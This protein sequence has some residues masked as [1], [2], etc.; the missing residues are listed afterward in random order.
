VIE[1]P[2][3]KAHTPKAPAR[4]DPIRAGLLCRCPRCGKGKLFSGFLEVARACDACGADFTRL[5]TG[6]GATVF[7]IQ[8]TG[9][10][11][12]FGL[13]FTQ[14]ALNPPLWVLAAVWL[15]LTALIGLGLMRPLK[16]AMIGLQIRNRAGEVRNDDF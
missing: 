11:V 12:V 4:I 13:L 16:G 2:L 8:I 14:V 10:I 7:V 6:D 15:P 1:D 5:N 9:F 3:L